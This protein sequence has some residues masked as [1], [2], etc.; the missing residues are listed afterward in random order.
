MYH[1][2]AFRLFSILAHLKNIL[3]N[4]D[5]RQTNGLMV[6]SVFTKH[7]LKLAI[8]SSDQLSNLSLRYIGWKKVVSRYLYINILKSK[9]KMLSQLTGNCGNCERE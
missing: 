4:K 8:A 9:V 2:S 1:A 6:H 5:L 3:F 7:T